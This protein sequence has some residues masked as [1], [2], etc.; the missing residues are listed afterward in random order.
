[1]LK[2][3]QQ[4]TGPG[5]WCIS[6]R[7]SLQYAFMQPFCTQNGKNS[8]IFCCSECKRVTLTL[9]SV[10]IYLL[11]VCLY[12]F[13]PDYQSFQW[14]VSIQLLSYN[15][16]YFCFMNL[17]L[18]QQTC[19]LSGYQDL[20]NFSQFYLVCHLSLPQKWMDALS[21]VTLPFSVSTPFSVGI[22]YLVGSAPTPF[23]RTSFSNQANKKL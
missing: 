3:Q 10:A 17:L 14:W 19:A 11:K 4:K 2:K 16:I 6:I 5:V 18:V 1:M 7:Q 23:G 8:W 15:S 21:H 13:L 20:T 9:F 22:N 12:I